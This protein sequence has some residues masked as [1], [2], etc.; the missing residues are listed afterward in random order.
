MNG[1]PWYWA[2]YVY[3]DRAYE[4]IIAWFR[5]GGDAR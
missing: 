4:I 3:V 5:K 1:V 2:W